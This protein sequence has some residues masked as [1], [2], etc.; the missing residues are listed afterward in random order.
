MRN[1]TSA[2]ASPATLADESSDVGSEE[3]DDEEEVDEHEEEEEVCHLDVTFALHAAYKTGKLCRPHRARME[4]CSGGACACCLR[5]A[6]H[7]QLLHACRARSGIFGFLIVVLKPQLFLHTITVLFVS[8]STRALF[9]QDNAED[10]SED[11][12]PARAS[13]PKATNNG[14][15]RD[16]PP[17]A[18]RR[19]SGATAVRQRTLD[20]GL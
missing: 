16:E 9:M 8:T 3:D 20:D 11:S 6:R 5:S 7:A 19:A 1:A 18:K 2:A 4:P 17:A 14:G 10:E 15:G 12:E 13:D